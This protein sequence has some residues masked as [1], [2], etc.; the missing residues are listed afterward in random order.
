[1]GMLFEL[2]SRGELYMITM[3]TGGGYGDILERDPEMV[4]TD[5]R[6]N[7]ISE[8]TAR[9]VYR[10]ILDPDTG[11][12]N[13]EATA[14]ARAAERRARLERG[15]PY[16]EFVEEWETELPPT[17][18]PDYGSWNDPRVLHLGTQESTCPSDAIA[19]VFM[20]DPK[21]VRIAKL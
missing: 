2:A 11:V 10:V 6:D 18:V 12:V 19:A 21:D 17:E 7:L 5:F 13:T 16:A 20:P 3:G 1:M 4:S 15:K 9:E 14:T 8:W